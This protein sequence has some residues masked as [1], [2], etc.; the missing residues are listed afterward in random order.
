MDDKHTT[1]KQTEALS[2]VPSTTGAVI[3]AREVTSAPGAAIKAVK[4]TLAPAVRQALNTGVSKLGN[5]R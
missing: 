4:L 5:V 2:K 1:S 3:I